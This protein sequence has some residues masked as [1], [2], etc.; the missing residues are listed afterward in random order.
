MPS[1]IR[2]RKLA[3]GTTTYQA[4]VPLPNGDVL[5]QAFER[6]KDARVWVGKKLDERNH[7]QAVKPSSQTLESFLDEWLVGIKG[8]LRENTFESYSNL[9][10]LYI[11]PRLGRIPLKRLG[12]KSIEHAYGEMEAQGLSSRTIRY[13]HSV[14]HGALATADGMTGDRN[15]AKAKTK[16]DKVG[17]HLPDKEQKEFRAL[18]VDEA[19]GFLAIVDAADDALDDRR[20]G[21]RAKK[22]DAEGVRIAA[23]IAALFHIL[24]ATGL[25]PSEAFALK[26]D[27]VNL[28]PDDNG[29]GS[30]TVRKSLTRL[31][32]GE[33]VLND[34][35]TKNSRRTVPIPPQTL[36]AVRRHRIRQQE[37]RMKVGGFWRDQGFIFTNAFGDPL[38]IKNTVRRHFKPAMR[39]LAAQL[40]PADENGVVS[41]DVKALRDE[42]IGTRLYD[43]RHACATFALKQKINVKVVSRRLGHKSIVTTLDIYAHVLDEMQEEATDEL[44]NVLYG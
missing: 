24:L 10:E 43:L 8:S 23:P 34:P 39:K 7:G 33:W 3:N 37:H 38:E 4:R 28:D 22:E 13:V 1:L 40:H 44:G 21:A 31:K 30:V 41:P 19:R 16:N 11:K 27:S 18:K 42:L 26:W 9:I 29:R 2:K 25:R 35:K 32:G 20:P 5:Y 12:R 6:E 15:P 14:L 17:V 36:G